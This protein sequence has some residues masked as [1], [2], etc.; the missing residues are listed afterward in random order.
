[1]NQRRPLYDGREV[2]NE[3]R[4]RYNTV[5]ES[6]AISL[7]KSTVIPSDSYKWKARAA[8]IFESGVAIIFLYAEAIACRFDPNTNRFST[9]GFSL[10]RLSQGFGKSNFIA[11]YAF[12]SS[13]MIL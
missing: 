12:A 11:L 8:V 1:M 9:S 6:F 10:R 2:G 5:P 7:I 3:E 13:K 4:L